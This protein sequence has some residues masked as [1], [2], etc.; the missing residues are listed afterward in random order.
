[1]LIE[2]MSWTRL[3][4]RFWFRSTMFHPVRITSGHEP[5]TCRHAVR[6]NVEAVEFNSVSDKAIQIRRLH[7]RVSAK[8][9]NP[10]IEIIEKQAADT[11]GFTAMLEIKVLIAPL[12]VSRVQ[13]LTEWVANGFRVP[14]PVHNVILERVVRRQVEAATEP[15]GVW[16]PEH[17]GVHMNGRHM[18]VLHMRHQ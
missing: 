9:A 6:S 1:M 5:G 16:G 11:T 17:A 2:S 18:G 8:A 13:I 14:V 12:L 7:L 10:I 4:M 15:P 3:K